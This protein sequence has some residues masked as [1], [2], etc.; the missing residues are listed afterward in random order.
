MVF[1]SSARCQYGAGRIR[2]GAADCNPLG[3]GSFRSNPKSSTQLQA[4]S[5]RHCGRSRRASFWVRVPPGLPV[6]RSHQRLRCRSPKTE[7][8][9][10]SLAS[11]SNCLCSG[12]AHLVTMPFLSPPN[13]FSEVSTS[14]S[15]E[16]MLLRL[17]CC[18]RAKSPRRTEPASYRSRSG[19][20]CHRLRSR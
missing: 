2:F 16:G 12:V 20:S 5:R 15:L 13:D 4:R 8:S 3:L 7:P 11:G 14:A 19:E 9:S 10:S 17:R 6:Y 1:D 18:F